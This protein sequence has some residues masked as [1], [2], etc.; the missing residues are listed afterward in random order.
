MG[1]FKKDPDAIL[2]YTFDW[3]AWLAKKADSIA[4]RTV[5]V[6]AGITKDSD[7]FD[8]NTVTVWLSGGTA[9]ETYD[10]LCEIITAGSRKDHRTLTVHVNER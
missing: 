6:P 9:G 7:S 3:T 8:A 10:I 2:D 4:S 5:T 1:K